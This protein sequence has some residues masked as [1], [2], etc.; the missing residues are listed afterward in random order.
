MSSILYFRVCLQRS[1]SRIWRQSTTPFGV[2][3]GSPKR[4]LASVSNV[5]PPSAVNSDYDVVIV[6]S[7]AAGMTAGIRAKS[8]G[9]KPLIIEKMDVIGGCS[10]YSGGGL[11]I[12]T[13]GLH[14]G[15]E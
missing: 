6:G 4:F 15:V 2:Q 1:P 5:P 7:G 9:L 13:N 11:W 12:P 3:I 10:G 14:P 8:L